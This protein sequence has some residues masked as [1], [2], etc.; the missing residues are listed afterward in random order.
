MARPG[1]DGPAMA[2]PAEDGPAMDRP[3]VGGPVVDKPMS[4]F[5]LQ[6][7]RFAKNRLAMVSVGVLMLIA[8]CC[9]LGPFA[10]PF[11]GEDADFDFISAPVDFG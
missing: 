3:V 1:M 10:F 2:R 5:Q 7:R 4:T 11:T 6:L 9:F 8:L